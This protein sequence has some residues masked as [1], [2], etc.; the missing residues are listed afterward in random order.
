MLYSVV[1]ASLTNH[2]EY[3]TVSLLTE[4]RVVSNEYGL[5]TD[6]PYAMG[7]EIVVWNEEWSLNL[8]D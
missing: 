7:Q 5:D 8:R 2:I 3:T 4:G 1:F 6:K